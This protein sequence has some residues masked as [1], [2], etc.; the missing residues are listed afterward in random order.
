MKVLVTGGAGF[1]ARFVVEQLLRQE[2]S[3][4]I[5]DSLEPRAHHKPPVI[6]DGVEFHHCHVANLP[7]YA[8][9]DA[10]VVIHLAAQVGVGDS[11]VDPLRYVREN[12]LET[13]YMLLDLER[14]HHL[15]RIVVASSMAVYG[16][17]GVAVAESAPVVPMSVYGLTK[18]DQERQVRMWGEQHKVRNYALRFFNI[19]GPRQNL[20]NP[21]TGVLAN[22]ARAFLNDERPYIYEDGK[23][24]RDWIYVA[25]VAEAVCRAALAP[26]VPSGTYNVCTGHATS[27][28]D[29][30]LALGRALGKNLF[31]NVSHVYRPGDIR[32]CTGDPTLARADLGF[33]ART[34]L[35][36]GL[37]AYG[38]WLLNGGFTNA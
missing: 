13:A 14:C 4:V 10:D 8:Y 36:T 7:Y 1:V 30:T 26:D 32:H 35:D 33:A 24:T 21:Y 31:P 28:L 9:V 3:V 12:S 38:Q 22:F 5:A 27:L 15:Q 19:Y 23:Q 18:Y 16:E 11:M 2:C 29:A 34:T 37:M 20:H 6:P 17:G 25:D